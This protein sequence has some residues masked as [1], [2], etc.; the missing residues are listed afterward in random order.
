LNANLV[1]AK[2]SA[3]QM[4]RFGIVSHDGIGET[5]EPVGGSHGIQRKRRI[6]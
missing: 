1:T 6:M 3:A 5:P 4:A 2:A